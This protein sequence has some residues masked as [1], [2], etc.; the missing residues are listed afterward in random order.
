MLTIK[1]PK[2][3]G[4]LFTASFALTAEAILDGLFNGKLVQYGDGTITVGST[5]DQEAANKRYK[6]LD[7]FVNDILAPIG[8]ATKEEI[9]GLNDFLPKTDLSQERHL[10]PT[11]SSA[12][13]Y[14][15]LFLKQKLDKGEMP[16]DYAKKVYKGFDIFTGASR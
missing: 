3:Q 6:S 12:K 2:P 10:Y 16:E 15:D 11:I 1:I 5:V 13:R 7:Y 8:E 4:T 14:V 9:D